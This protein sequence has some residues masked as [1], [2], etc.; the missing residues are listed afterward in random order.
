MSALRLSDALSIL[1][2]VYVASS[3]HEYT[4]FAAKRSRDADDERSIDSQTVTH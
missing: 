4:E 2:H 3:C 1:S